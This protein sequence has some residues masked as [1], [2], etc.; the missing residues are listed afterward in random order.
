MEDN[1]TKT[2]AI[3]TSPDAGWREDLLA[4]RDLNDREKQGY[5]FLLSWHETWR[6]GRRLPVG[7]E[8]A[9]SFWKVEVLAKARKAWQLEQWAEAVRWYLGWLELCQGSGKPVVSQA[10]RVRDAVERV[11]ARRGLALRTRQSYGSWAVRFA[12]WAGSRERILDPA[13]ARDWLG[14]LVAK[15]GVSYATQKQA[16]NALAFLYKDVCGMEEVDLGVKLRKTA[17]RI[18]VVLNM[19]EVMRLIEKLEPLYRLPAQLQYG[20]GL[21]IGELV[22]LRIKDVDTRRRQL[23]VRAG[24]GNKDRVTVLPKNLIEGIAEKKKDARELHEIDRREGLPGVALPNAL[25]RK[26]PKAGDVTCPTP[27]IR[28]AFARERL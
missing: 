26:M 24:K 12:A 8:A 10:E 3:N 23:T 18:P 4:S 21:R 14:D 5:A 27:L 17:K 22:S 20:A 7:C 25:V 15:T 13:C 2:Q 16:L 9:R 28:H 1:P 19:D 6:L 11:G